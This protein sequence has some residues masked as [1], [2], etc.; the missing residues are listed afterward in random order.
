MFVKI[1]LQ[2]IRGDS[3]ASSSACRSTRT[4]CREEAPE[5]LIAIDRA[6]EA[7]AGEYPRKSQLVELR[8]LG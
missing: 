7:L 2:N 4:F 1:A 3:W 6:L 5:D 8:F